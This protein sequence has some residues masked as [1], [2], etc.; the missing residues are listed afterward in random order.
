[1]DTLPLAFDIAA[2]GSDQE[3]ESIRSAILV[4][5]PDGARFARV[6]RR[7]IDMLLD[8]QNTGRFRWEQLHKTEKT[9]AGTLVEINL[10]R[11]FQ[12]AD[13]DKMDYKI[14]GVD[15][16][17]KFSQDIGKWMIPPEAVGHL[18]LVTWCNDYSE[19]WSVG[20]VRATEQALLDGTN[21]D[22]KRYL[23]PSGRAAIR[24]LFRDAPLAENV[25]LK[26]SPDDI[27]AIF[28]PDK[29]QPRIN[30]LFRRTLGRRVGRAVVA[31]V[32][33]QDDYM[34]R[35]RYNGGARSR[36]APEGIVILG[37][38]GSHVDVAAKLG[39]P[40]PRGG[41]SVSARLAEWTPTDG[42]V[43][44]VKID[45]RMWRVARTGDPVCHAP[46]LPER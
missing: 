23:N 6:F 44:R 3:L 13:G 11:E 37:Q 36:L 1:M 31:T 9:H 19:K 16:D 38:Y 35:I 7:T 25:L 29:G 8:G 24:W 46:L 27:S 26:L 43:P 34:K 40:V 30:E 39:L 18:C 28:A 2:P 17:C 12:F 22:K 20:L 42:D 15:V 10:Q 4:A 45:G 14:N 21:R 41:E 5:D 32:G 33:Q